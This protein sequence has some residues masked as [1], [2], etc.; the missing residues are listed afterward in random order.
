MLRYSSS[1]DFLKE[2]T[3]LKHPE[4]TRTRI[5]LTTGNILQMFLFV[6]IYLTLFIIISHWIIEFLKNRGKMV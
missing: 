1:T 5:V 6:S 4:R 2:N 3:T